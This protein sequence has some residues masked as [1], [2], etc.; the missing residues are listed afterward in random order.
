MCQ[1]FRY[2]FKKLL[3]SLDQHPEAKDSSQ[4]HKLAVGMQG[5]EV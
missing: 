3:L 5:E 2:N 1:I 4:L